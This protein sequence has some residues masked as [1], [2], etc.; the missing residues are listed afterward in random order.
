MAD[1]LEDLLRFC[2]VRITGGPISGA[3]F[4]VAPGKVLTCVHVVGV[5]TPLMVRWE[6]D[7]QPAL[8]VGVT[9]RAVM[10]TDKGRP[11][12]ALTED[13][14]DIAVLTVVDIAD[15]PCVAID[16]EWPLS[17]DNFQVFGYPRE[18]GAVR[19]T[20][21]QLSYRGTHGTAP[22]AF[23][24]LASD[25]IKPGMSGAA[26]LN[27]RTRAVCGVVVASKHPAHPDGALAVPWS[28]V[29]VDLSD[30][31]VAN[32]AFHA[33]D[34]RWHDAAAAR[35]TTSAGLGDK[36]TVQAQIPAAATDTL[37]GDPVA[38][39]AR[40]AELDQLM[41]ALPATE[42]AGG[43]VHIDAIDGMPG[44]GKTT[45]AV[46]AARQL[47]PAFSDGLL[48]LRLH[49]HT[50][51]RQPVNTADALGALLLADEV[52]P[53]QIPEGTEARAGLWRRRMA[54]RKKLLLFDDAI[55]SEQVRPL[56]PDS[57]RT[58]V[59]ITSRH[60]LTALPEALPVT[61]DILATDEA[62]RLF[63]DIAD[64]AD[65]QS[66]ADAVAD[67]VALCGHLPLAI[68]LMAGQLK[69]RPAWTVADLAA[70]LASAAD[71]LAL[72]TAENVSVAAAFDLSYRHLPTDEQQLF[73]RIGLHP[74]NDIDVYAAAALDG[75]ELAR[76]RRL[77]DGL[78]GYHLMEEPVR[79]RYRFHDLIREHARTLA[80]QEEAS[81]NDAAVTRLLD[82]YLHVARAADSH[83]ARRTPAGVPAVIVNQPVSIPVF[84]AREQAVTWMNNERLN[85]H[86]AADYAARHS[87]PAYPIAIAAA[88]QAF[89]AA[90][91]Y[92]HQAIDLNGIAIDAAH[93]ISDGTAEASALTDLAAIQRIA[94]DNSAAAD[95]LARA[96]ELCTDSADQLG[97]AN[98][99][100]EMSFIQYL[101]GEYPAATHSLGQALKSYRDIGNR[102]GEAHA[103]RVLGAVHALTDKYPAAIASLNRALERYQELHDPL[104][105]ASARN[106]LGIVRRQTGEYTEAIADL[107]RALELYR[108]LGNRLGEAN[109]LNNLSAAQE[110]SGD[111]PAA[112]ANITSALKLYRELGHP[113]GEAHALNELGA[114]QRLTGDHKAAATSLSQALDLRRRAGNLLGEA[115]TLNNMGDLSLVVGTLTDVRARHEDAL[116]I[117]TSIGSPLEEARAL[118]GIGRCDLRDGR[119]EAAAETLR[120]ALDIY[121]RIGSPNSGRVEDILRDQGL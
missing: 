80:S 69:H 6:R 54:D 112:I 21:A 96:L 67:V 58:L 74:G 12:P 56:L 5:S 82:F 11:I 75:I 100:T 51:G 59:L 106:D 25:T 104:G 34:Q 117:A 86:A 45:F 55:S 70:D 95:N 68:V 92:W 66:D 62:A 28:A 108:K 81:E 15:H 23:L 120:R 46:H 50:P 94:G 29:I 31:I 78:F 18:G 119:P 14:P 30:V 52:A 4:F 77:L 64:R 109:A 114:L 7:G 85:L 19:L 113:I 53:Q 97:T 83:L 37:P 89:L 99:H 93:A 88:M 91:G 111:N 42:T 43:V 26:V 36:V 40:Q 2:T 48:F 101:R 1:Q 121:R 105:E 116:R 47:S 65:L 90:R 115:E 57:P 107:S 84:R 118:E 102:L 22:T 61:L 103:L 87:L 60:R 3:G 110:A 76:A 9:D 38:F 44:I 63:V 35:S 27:L 39:T 49:G 73:R 17:G 8:E 10:L 72:M 13:Y 33:T 16:T 32:R 71:R 20:P 98:A 41:R 24:D 79:G